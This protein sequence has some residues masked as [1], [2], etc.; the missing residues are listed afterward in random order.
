MSTRRI[1]AE[2]LRDSA[3]G[4]LL[5]VGGMAIV[6]VLRLSFGWKSRLLYSPCMCIGLLPF[7]WF[8]KR[9]GAIAFDLV[10]VFAWLVLCILSARVLSCSSVTAW[11]DEHTYYGTLAFAISVL[12]PIWLYRGIREFCTSKFSRKGPDS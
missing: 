1:V 12:G 3:I 11:L 9:K 10:D 6:D 8:A 7:L 2:W 4:F 5:L